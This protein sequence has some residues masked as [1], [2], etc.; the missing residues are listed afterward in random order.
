MNYGSKPNFHNPTRNVR[1]FGVSGDTQT[2]T[3]VSAPESALQCWVGNI[4]M[5]VLALGI[6]MYGLI[7]NWLK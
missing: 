7:G 6:P 2:S 5:A 1:G 4:V 3:S